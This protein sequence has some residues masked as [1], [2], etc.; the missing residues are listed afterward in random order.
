MYHYDCFYICKDLTEG[1]INQSINGEAKRCMYNNQLTNST[2]KIRTTWNIIKT[3]TNRSKG[4]LNTI[5]NNSVNS[6]EAYNRYFLSIPRNIID[7]NRSKSNQSTNT[8]KNPNQY[9]SNLFPTLFPCI[10]F[11]NTSA[12]ENEKLLVP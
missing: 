11:R 3:E 5:T 1:E 2:N 4:P 10:K 7:G 6:P 12:K 8:T 9:L